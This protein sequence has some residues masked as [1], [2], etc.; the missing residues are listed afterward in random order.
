MVLPFARK[1]LPLVRTEGA[2][3]VQVLPFE[4]TEGTLIE[5]GATLLLAPR[6]TW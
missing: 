4:R 3:I 5:H 1:G 2:L 6:V